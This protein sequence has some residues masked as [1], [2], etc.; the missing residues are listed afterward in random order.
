ML[1]NEQLIQLSEKFYTYKLFIK[2]YYIKIIQINYYFF[3]AI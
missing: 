3:Q 1:Q 2:T